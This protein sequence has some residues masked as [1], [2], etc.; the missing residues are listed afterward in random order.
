M[1]NNSDSTFAL[2]HVHL[3][4][5]DLDESIPFYKDVLGLRVQERH[6]RYVFM[7]WGDK[8]HDVALQE[9]AGTESPNRG[10]GLYHLAVEVPDEKALNDLNERVEEWT[11]NVT[12]VDHGISESLYFSDPDGIGIEVYRDTRREKNAQYWKGQTK[13]L[14]LN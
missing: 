9:A 10:P 13:S 3:K 8:H 7:S 6:N 4:V 14:S 11:T 5:S 1:V 2:G 12:A